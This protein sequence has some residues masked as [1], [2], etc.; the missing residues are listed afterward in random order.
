MVSLEVWA[1]RLSRSLLINPV[2]DTVAKIPLLLSAL[3]MIEPLRLQLR[4]A[5]RLVFEK[6]LMSRLRLRIIP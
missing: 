2:S 5:T 6:D 1:E 4:S 3:G